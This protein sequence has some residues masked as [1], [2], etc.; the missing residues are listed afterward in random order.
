[1]EVFADWQL[2]D[3]VARL[4]DLSTKAALSFASVLLALRIFV[5]VFKS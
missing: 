1:M 4:M 2:A 3:M 5:E